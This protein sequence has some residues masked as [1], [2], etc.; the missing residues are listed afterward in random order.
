METQTLDMYA[1]V[2]KV[3]ATSDGIA[4]TFSIPSCDLVHILWSV[5]ERGLVLGICTRWAKDRPQL[6]LVAS[7]GN[8]QRLLEYL[9]ER[10]I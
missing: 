9:S 1:E 3:I 2:H 10:A 5:Y 8:F 6:T 4:K 7:L